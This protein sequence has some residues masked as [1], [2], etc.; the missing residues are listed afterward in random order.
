MLKNII[1]DVGSVLL[2]YRWKEL[3]VDFG[4]SEEDAYRVGKEMF[5]DPDGLWHIYDLATMSDEEIADAYAEK[6]PDDEKAIRWFLS[7]GE[8]M[9]IPRPDIWEQVHRLKQKGYGIYLLS[10][11]PKELFKKH[12]QYADFMNDIDGLMVSY[13]IHKAK[14]DRE[15]YSALCEKYGLDK[16]ECLFFDDRQENVDGAIAFGMPALVAASREELLNELKKL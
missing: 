7:H 11:Y 10:N 8:Y 12:T 1:F 9:H 16:S 13:M 5:D 14:P 4:L 15:I 6:Y 3:L 2:D